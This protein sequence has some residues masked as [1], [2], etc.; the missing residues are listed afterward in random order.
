MYYFNIVETILRD[1]H[2]FFA[3]IRNRVVL[4]NKISS[5]LIACLIFLAL[6]GIVMGASHRILQAISSMIKLPILFLVTLLICTPSLHYFNILFGSKQT[7]PQTVA[8]VLTAITTTAVLLLSFAAIT[9]FFLIT[10]S[11]YT[12]F[13]LLNVSFFAL[14]GTMGILF[15]RQGIRLGQEGDT[16]EGKGVRYL[17]F[18]LWV[19]LYG[20]VGSQMAWT[21]SPFI[22]RPDEPFGIVSQ[23]GG[24][25]YS[26]VITSLRELVIR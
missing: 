3:E 25:F 1:R 11:E 10:S 2:T 6:Y 22:G 20:F 23:V 16:Q 4:G 12:F 18:V 15:R 14:A 21:L 24:N 19:I 26:D 7:L 17:I 8:L 13:K 9:L 5:R